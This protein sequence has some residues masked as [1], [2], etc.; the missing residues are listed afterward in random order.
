MKIA[1]LPS[2]A[3][4]A[5]AGA[6]LAQDRPAPQGYLPPNSVDL[7][8]VIPPAPSKGDIRYETDRKIFKA[9]EKKVGGERWRY[10][11]ADIKAD[12]P[13]ML[14]DFECAAGFLLD[15]K[16]L[17]ATSKLLATASIDTNSANNAAK[18][19]W[20]RLRPFWI[21][22]GET[23]EPKDELGKSFDYP[24]GHS[25]K[26]WTL[27][28]LLAELLPDRANAILTR[29]RAYGESR[30]VCRVHN[31]S[32][33][34]NG[35]LG[36][37]VTLDQVRTQA[38]FQRDLAAARIELAAARAQASKPDAGRC[39]AEMTALEPSVIAGLTK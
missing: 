23:C 39:S 16:A 13:T 38:A 6:A 26:G 15:T 5:V 4:F 3:V 36:A 37:A 17:P 19:H 18:E 24:S 34:E 14:H 11:V 30:I 32:A 22:K 20:Q 12:T 10:A 2:L 8:R 29:A 7:V 9:M 27:G 25:T 21:D 33:V 35:R 28:L 1:L 31:M